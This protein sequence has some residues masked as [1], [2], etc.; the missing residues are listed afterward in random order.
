LA[1]HGLPFDPALVAEGNFT[2]A[3]GLVAANALLDVVP[4]PDAIAAANDDMAAAV[5]WAAHS[6]GLVL[7]RDLSVTGFDD[8][9]LAT[10]VWPALTTIRQ[11]IRQMVA[12]A[13]DHLTT[14][15]GGGAGVSDTVLDFTL[16]ERDSV[17]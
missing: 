12:T 2:F 13:V 16:V 1:A 10:R 14:A 17:V 5:L 8:T 4:R 3:S 6:R 15:L 7:P 11:P 9:L